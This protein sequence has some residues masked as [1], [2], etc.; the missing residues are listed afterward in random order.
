ME[1]RFNHAFPP[2]CHLGAESATTFQSLS[3]FSKRRRRFSTWFGSLLVKNNKSMD[4]EY[5]SASVCC[6]NLTSPDF[7]KKTPLHW[8][9]EQLTSKPAISLN[10]RCVICN[11]I[12]HQPVPSS[13]HTSWI[14][15]L[16]HLP[17]RSQDSFVCVTCCGRPANSMYKML[18]YSII[19]KCYIECCVLVSSSC[20]ISCYFYRTRVRSLGMLV[21]DSL[22]HS[23]TAV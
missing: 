13:M 23:L 2:I 14:K 16:K 7:L 21:S 9:R 5:K 19:I 22:T 11:I 18:N 17:C 6:D 12:S 1:L 4:S 8:P 10:G 3:A 15:R 20:S